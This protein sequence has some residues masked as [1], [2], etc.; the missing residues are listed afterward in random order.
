M[1]TQ[2]VRPVATRRETGCVLLAMLL[3]SLGFSLMV[4]HRTRSEPEARLEAYQLSAFSD[5]NDAEQGIFSDLYAAAVEIDDMHD[6]DE[7]WPRI[8]ELEEMYLA[9]FLKDAAWERR[10]KLGWTVATLARSSLHTAA[11]IGKTSLPDVSGSFLLLFS[12]YNEEQ[13]HEQ[14]DAAHADKELIHIWYAA[15]SA[16]AIP[17]DLSVYGLIEKGWKTV[18]PYKGEEEVRRLKGGVL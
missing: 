4:V 18:I 14:H 9:P 1:Y 13:E 6:S 12:H 15:G 7:V 8:A 17:D 3:V 5:L 2:I 10:G 11:Y 16:P